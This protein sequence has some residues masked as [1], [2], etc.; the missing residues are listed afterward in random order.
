MS[1]TQS[2]LHLQGMLR[3]LPAMRLHDLDQLLASV[4]QR[5]HIIQT[6]FVK[7]SSP[8]EASDC[9]LAHVPVAVAA[10][11]IG[12][13]LT[14][15]DA[16]A[17]SQCSKR[18]LQQLQQRAFLKCTSYEIA[19]EL[20]NP[21]SRHCAAFGLMSR[22]R[23]ST[24]A[25]WNCIAML[26]SHVH[27]LEFD[28]RLFDQRVNTSPIVPLHIP[29]CI[30]TVMCSR[31]MDEYVH[32]SCASMLYRLRLPSGLQSLH[33]PAVR[34]L[35]LES[36]Q[37]RHFPYELPSSLTELS[38]PSFGESIDVYPQQW[39]PN[40]RILRCWEGAPLSQLPPLPLS[41][42]EL[43]TEYVPPKHYTLLPASLTRLDWRYATEYDPISLDTL[44][45]PLALEEFIFSLSEEQSLVQL[46]ML[47]SPRLRELRLDLCD[48]HITTLQVTVAQTKDRRSMCLSAL[49][50]LELQF[51]TNELRLVATEQL[52]PYLSSSCK[53]VFIG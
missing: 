28:K 42:T 39:P 12:G 44:K 7:A 26:P 9:F 15:L 40:L 16:V 33:M 38:I 30:T 46:L 22:V 4:Q 8:P 21:N 18:S 19:L 37:V 6:S 3:L 43:D 27:V 2:A 11:V 14:D 45:L 36:D 23:I 48:I 1:F 29:K 5:R 24:Q 20:A 50:K 52:T 10:H 49:R 47:L 41:L 25:D 51:P 13:F 31:D 53:I 17:W 34:Y 32:R 35:N